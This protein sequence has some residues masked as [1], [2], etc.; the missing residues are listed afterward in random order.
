M[1]KIFLSI[2][3]IG[4]VGA[5]AFGASRAFF[6]DSENIL[7]N[8]I[9]AGDI[10][11]DV[12]NGPD[13][14]LAAVEIQDMK[15]SYVRWTRHVVTNT[16]TNPVR[17]WKHIT[18]VLTDENEINE[19]EGEW[20]VD[21]Q[22][23]NPPG[24]NNIDE[25]I[26]YDM[27][28]GGE[29]SGSESDNWL[30]GVNTDGQVVISEDDGITLADIESVYVY[31]EELPVN[32]SITVWQSYHMKDET[33]NW[34]QT[35]IVTFDIEFYGEQVNG[36]GPTSNSL[37]LENKET[38]AWNPVIGDGIWGVLKWSGDGNTFNYSLKAVGLDDNLEYSLIYYA[39]PWPGNNPGLLIDSGTPIGGQLLLSQDKDLGLD[40]PE[41]GDANYPTGAKIWLIPSDYYSGTSVIGWP[42][43]SD[44]PPAG[45]LFE[46]NLIK[47]DD[48][49]HS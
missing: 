11:I 44:E 15:P 22:I 4:I 42:A 46:Y 41:P 26:E 34:A 39:D 12:T 37:L 9:I 14:A 43:A 16:G 35:D 40:L 47:Y 29:V 7:G 27:Y 24:R 3:T 19:A 30:G 20:Y 38:N 13:T 45:W 49:D 6:S 23:D 28:I 25:Y 8:K 36:T 31:L 18:N 10:T 1:R 32:E 2:M 21:N 33:E 48:L 5:L 17:V